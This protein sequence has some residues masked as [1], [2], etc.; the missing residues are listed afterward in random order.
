MQRKRIQNKLNTP[1]YIEDLILG[2]KFPW[3]LNIYK[4]HQF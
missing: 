3:E 2:T 4:K 1:S